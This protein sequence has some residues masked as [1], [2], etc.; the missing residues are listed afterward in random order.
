MPGSHTEVFIV[1]VYRMVC[2]V[3][4]ACTT[5][6]HSMWFLLWL[7]FSV[8]YLTCWF[9]SSWRDRPVQ[10]QPQG[11]PQELFTQGRIFQRN[12]GLAESGTWHM[13]AS[14][15]FPIVTC[16]HLGPGSNGWSSESACVSH[17]CFRTC[18]FPHHLLCTGH[19]LCFRF[20]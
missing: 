13:T 12:P 7:C 2:A 20:L 8:S 4:I 17:L 6:A 11:S 18:C 16:L 19:W 14:A 1:R 9:R 3:S 10:G 15:L 5:V